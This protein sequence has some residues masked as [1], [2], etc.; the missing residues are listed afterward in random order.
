MIASNPAQ[1]AAVVPMPGRRQ[2]LAEQAGDVLQCHR[3]GQLEHRRLAAA[4]R[5]HHSPSCAADGAPRG[6]TPASPGWFAVEAYPTSGP[7]V[8]EAPLALGHV[9]TEDPWPDRAGDVRLNGR[10]AGCTRWWF[11]RLQLS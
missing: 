9:V 1:L 2:G 8:V 10:P 6:D 4:E 11:R 3:V 5:H 7:F